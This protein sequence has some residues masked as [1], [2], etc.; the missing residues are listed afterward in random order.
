MRQMIG[1]KVLGVISAVACVAT[2]AT[3]A[4]LR[5]CQDKDLAEG[6]YRMASSRMTGARAEQELSYMKSAYA[7]IVP[8]QVSEGLF[9]VTRYVGLLSEAELSRTKYE[10]GCDYEL[11]GTKKFNLSRHC[12]VRAVN[13]SLECY[14]VCKIFEQR[15][16]SGGG[17]CR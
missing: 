14:D 7:R 2:V 5:L 4:D 8:K 15:D 6:V 1:C 13:D 16:E 10:G 17:D 3:A 9:S 12:D 11:I